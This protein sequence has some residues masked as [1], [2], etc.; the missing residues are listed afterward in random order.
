[1]GSMVEILQ[2]ERRPDIPG[3]N[4]SLVIH[5]NGSLMRTAS[6]QLAGIFVD[7]LYGKGAANA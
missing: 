1:M 2:P 5:P 6:S 3:F 4:L 7:L